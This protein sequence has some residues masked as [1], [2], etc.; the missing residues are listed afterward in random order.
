MGFRKGNNNRS[1]R[2]KQLMEQY[3]TVSF[4]DMRNIK[5]DYTYPD[6]SEFIVSVLKQLNVE[7]TQP[8]INELRL[9]MINWNRKATPDNVDATLFMVSMYYIFKKK[10]YNDHNFMGPIVIE[11]ELV[12]EA[13][14]Y[15][16]NYLM[17]HHGST[18]VPLSKV[19]LVRRGNVELPMP[20][21]PDALAANYS[22]QDVATG[23]YFGYVGDSYTMLVEYDANGPARIETLHNYGSSARPDSPHYTD[24]MQLFSKQQTKT[25]TMDWEEIVKSAERVYK[26]Q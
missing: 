12:G 13:L 6:N 3:R 2:F 21:F 23:K 4:E 15:T 16:H 1:T 5:F 22:K 10:D 20:G 25:M 11:K 24:Q 9:R 18:K 7:C 14:Q 17:Q 19:Q 8:E 26:P